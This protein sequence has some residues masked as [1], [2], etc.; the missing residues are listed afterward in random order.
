MKI[1]EFRVRIIVGA[2]VPEVWNELV[3]WKNQGSWMALTRVEASHLGPTDSGIGTTID[4]FTGI[5]K[6]G[7]LDRM[8]VIE[9]NPPKFCKVDHYGRFIKGIGTFELIENNGVTVF[10]WY[11]EIKAPKAL[12]I[13]L[14]PFILIAVYASLRKFA[15]GFTSS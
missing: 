7:I 10:D 3:T 15:R 4:A 9:W 8:K 2:S 11:E 1:E 5:G 13:L 14:K 12:L 6:I